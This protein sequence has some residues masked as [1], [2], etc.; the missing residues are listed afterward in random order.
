MNEE[1]FSRESLSIWTGN[2]KEA[3][4]DSKRLNK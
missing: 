1:S 3:W 4:L 2:N